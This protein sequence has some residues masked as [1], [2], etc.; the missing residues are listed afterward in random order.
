M[1][2]HTDLYQLTMAAGYFHHGM[3]QKRVSMELFVRKL[4]SH[5]RFLVSAGL[6]RVVDSLRSLRFT[7]AQIDYL[8]QVPSL[9]KAMSL[10]FSE[11][12][13]DF[14]FRGDLWAMKEGTVVFEQE[15]LLRITGNLVEAQLVETLLLSIVNTETAV[16]SK[17]ARIVLAAQGDS[18]LEFGTR[19]TSPEE[20]VASARAAYLAGFAATSN[21]EAGFRYDMPISGTAAHSWTMAHESEQQAFENY[22]DTFG[23]NSLLL[24]D[25]YDTLEGTRRAIEAAGDQLKGVRLDSGDLLEL[26]ISVRK[27]LDEAGLKDAI[28]VASGDLNEYRIKELKAQG[29]QIDYWGV[30][31]EL[32]RCK[33]APSLGGVYKLVYDHEL[34]RPVAKLSSGKQTLPGCHQVYR[35]QRDGQFCEDVIGHDKEFHVNAEPLLTQFLKEGE[36]CQK[37]P[38][39]AQSRAHARAQLAALPKDIVAIEL[40]KPLQ[41]YPVRISSGLETT[42]QTVQKRA[43]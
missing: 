19:R 35:V 28:I 25:T 13:K 40:D 9:R 20:A 39:L 21:V 3:H 36:L 38:S 8:R 6:N 26:S 11:Y 34:D 1:A 24:V 22:V 5:R 14:R 41:N 7:E 18:V 16:A 23:N 43:S 27:L 32:A 15:P 4:P 12:L 33:D 29:A 17:A 10:E 42:I 37:V 31:T 2:L 30:G